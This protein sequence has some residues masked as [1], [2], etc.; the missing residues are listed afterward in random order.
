M[1]IIYAAGMFLSDRFVHAS[2]FSEH[3]MQLALYN[4]SV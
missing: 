2:I 4:R 3:S 1:D